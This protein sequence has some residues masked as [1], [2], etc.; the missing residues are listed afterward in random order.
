[1]TIDLCGLRVGS[2][3]PRELDIRAG[4]GLRSHARQLRF[5]AFLHL[6]TAEHDVDRGRGRGE[7]L[8]A[9]SG[10]G[11]AALPALGTRD[12]LAFAIWINDFY[13][14]RVA[15][16]ARQLRF[17]T[18]LHFVTAEHDVDRGMTLGGKGASISR[19]RQDQYE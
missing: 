6:V 15:L 5:N 7:R 13:I 8:E 4:R 14:L 2:R 3:A 11:Q 16:R 12:G 9:A 19:Q 1:M 17:N 18:F 10:S